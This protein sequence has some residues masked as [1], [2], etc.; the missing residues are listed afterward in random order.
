[1][2]DNDLRGGINADHVRDLDR[3]TGEA[4]L[5]H[6]HVTLDD[7]EDVPVR[8]RAVVYTSGNHG[9]VTAVRR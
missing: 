1:M 8:D 2:L 7:F 5:T 6:Q 3:R 4:V 9:D